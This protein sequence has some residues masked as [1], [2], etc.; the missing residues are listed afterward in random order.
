M[1]ILPSYEYCWFLQEEQANVHLAKLRKA[2]HDLEEAQERA[3]IA[4]SQVNKM[5]TRSR[6]LGKVILSCICIELIFK[7]ILHILCKNNL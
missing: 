1:I 6:E 4:E 5:R 7:K 3:D 2:Q